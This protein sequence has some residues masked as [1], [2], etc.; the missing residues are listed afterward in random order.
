MVLREL[1]IKEERGASRSEIDQR[2]KIVTFHLFL[3]FQLIVKIP[4]RRKTIPAGSA[5]DKNS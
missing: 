2:G 4:E 3:F 1:L 5:P